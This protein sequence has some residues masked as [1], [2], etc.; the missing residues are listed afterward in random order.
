M[1]LTT[2]QK[3]SKNFKK[4]IGKG[5]STTSKAFYEE[6][7][8]GRMTI[9]PSQIW[10]Q[11]SEIPSTAPALAPDAISGVVQYKEDLV[12]TAV[13]GTTNAFYHADLQNAIPF[14]YGDGSSYLYTIKDSTDSPIAPGQGDWVVDT[15]AGILSFYSSTPSNMP[16]KISFYR[17]VG[18]VGLQTADYRS[19]AVETAN[20]TIYLATTGDDETGDGTSGSPFFSLHRAFKDIK[21]NL[22]N[23][24]ITIKCDKGTYD[25]SSLG[26]LTIDKIGVL[27]REQIII[28]HNEA[29]VIASF[30]TLSVSGNFDN[31]STKFFT[32]TDSGKS[33]T[34][35]DYIGKFVK[36]MSLHAG[37]LP[38]ID[39]KTDE[40]LY[41]IASND[42]TSLNCAQYRNNGK[43]NF[44]AYEL[45]ENGIVFNMGTNAI[46]IGDVS[47][48]WTAVKITTELIE[49]LPTQ[50]YQIFNNSHIIHSNKSQ[51][52]NGFMA[53]SFVN[54]NGDSIS[55]SIFK[56]SV[57]YS[58]SF[59]G[60]VTE[61]GDLTWESSI[62][63]GQGYV[64]A[65][66]KLNMQHG[67][68]LTA[69]YPILPTGDVGLAGNFQFDSNA[70]F[71][72]LPLPSSKCLDY[73]STQ[74]INYINEPVI[75]RVSFD[76]ASEIDNYYDAESGFNYL[77]IAPDASKE[78]YQG[79]LP[80]DYRNLAVET[81]N[82]TIYVATTGSDTTGDGSSGT[83]FAS[84][85]RALKD[86]K[87]NIARGITITI[88]MGTGT[89]TITDDDPYQSQFRR[90]SGGAI[91][92]KP[93]SGSEWSVAESGTM[94]TSAFFKHTDTGKSWTTNE[95][96]GNYLRNGAAGELF[97]IESNTA[98]EIYHGGSN[99]F[100]SVN[101]T[102]YDIL[103]HN[104]IIDGTTNKTLF[105]YSNTDIKFEYVKLNEI[106]FL[107]APV[108]LSYTSILGAAL[109]ISI[110]GSYVNNKNCVQVSS[111]NS[112]L[113]GQSAIT[114]T[115]NS[116]ASFRNSINLSFFG[117]DGTKATDGAIKI[118]S[119]PTFVQPTFLVTYDLGFRNFKAGFTSG[120]AY[121]FARLILSDQYS[122]YGT[123]FFAWDKYQ[124]FQIIDDKTFGLY[125]SG[126]PPSTAY[127]TF[128]GTTEAEYYINLQTGLDAELIA[129]DGNKFAVAPEIRDLDIRSLA[130]ET[131]TRTI[132]LATTGDDDTGDG[133]SGSPF[134]SLH[135]AFKD[136]KPLVNATITIKCADGYY[137][138]TSLGDCVAGFK[139]INDGKV[140]ITTENASVD[141]N[142]KSLGTPVTGTFTSNDADRPIHTDSGASF[143][144][145]AFMGK[146]LKITSVLSG[147][148][149][150]DADK[151]V[152]IAANDTT[153]ITGAMW[154]VE[155]HDYGA[156]E[157]V[158]HTVHLDFGTSNFVSFPEAPVDIEFKEIEV[159]C[160]SIRRE[161]VGSSAAWQI[162]EYTL[163]SSKLNGTIELLGQ[164][165][166]SY[167][168]NTQGQILSYVYRSV[169][170]GDNT[171]G[172][173][174]GV[175]GI[176][177]SL[178]GATVRQLAGVNTNK[179]LVCSTKTTPSL[180]NVHAINTESILYNNSARNIDISGKISHAG[181]VKFVIESLITRN[182]RIHDPYATLYGGVYAFN[183]VDAV[184]T[185]RLTFDGS[186]EVSKYCDADSSLNALDIAPT[187][188][189]ISY[190]SFDLEIDDET[191]GII[192]TTPDGTTRYRI[193]IDNSGNV[194]TTS[195]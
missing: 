66:K 133:S 166:Q 4:L 95:H 123:D 111:W 189:Q 113:L 61:Y 74:P 188:N 83:P 91:T 171:T 108:Q 104:V 174:S 69:N 11:E 145:D 88:E 178:T 98:T 86:I 93:A 10:D 63:N 80:L 16:P 139:C 52:T 176:S 186:T 70:L 193:T 97:P 140:I 179:Y 44:N 160:Y 25:Y 22:G 142:F 136:I 49:S 183:L 43:S 37:T 164:I 159:T 148:T 131:S 138:F 135:R 96:R 132:Y 152:P 75:G 169:L 130:V 177:S 134:F 147:S 192:M 156:Y 60:I 53:Y 101:I 103:E 23:K 168:K 6:P 153:T 59:Y 45:F 150:S 39:L 172:G 112:A 117:K 126:L 114:M 12:L 30:N 32:Q 82:R 50:K 8:S 128:D 14:D 35:N 118:F 125:D 110:E 76:F 92:I 175:G 33:W 15:E 5:E 119:N 41:P 100:A 65:N 21:P 31:S 144:T 155:N 184:T 180:F 143:T 47:T 71:H 48:S 187:A 46:K 34:P 58:S 64:I 72:I 54:S 116:G 190:T 17:Y 87:S 56:S 115:S 151:Y 181:G 27:E 51:I 120:S 13:P 29:S 170:V 102:A 68:F 79:T 107:S 182:L 154:Y 81:S 9:L 109:N 137:D 84:L 127:L 24:V 67:M 73:N 122:F 163:Q 106:Q 158:E 195:L 146:F 121:G 105:D 38:S 157:V 57:N 19:L 90:F 194:I 26:D 78:L 7:L 28:T 94:N 55:V 99:T 3:A 62:Y 42:A 89:Y 129:P 124:N 2:D 191:K 149:L 77:L 141:D 18:T 20:R 165:R 185:A 36:I 167:V 40:T 1:A 85:L 162:Y 173:I 161:N